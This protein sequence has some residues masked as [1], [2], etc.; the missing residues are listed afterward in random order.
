MNISFKHH[1]VLMTGYNARMNKQIYAASSNL[2][3]A[4]RKQ[5]VRA[6]FGTIIMTLN[7]VMVGD[8]LWLKRFESH[9]SDFPK[10]KS[11]QAFPEFTGLDQVITENFDLLSEKRT[12][13]D[14]IIIDWINDDVNEQDFQ[15]PI[16]YS[17][18]KG[19]AYK[20][21]FAELLFHFFNHQTHHRGQLSTMLS[22][23][24]HDIGITDFLIDIPTE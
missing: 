9:P 16:E 15:H 24:G 3:D 1:F 4:Q 2:T 22:Q 20:R 19:I 5:D 17:D 14:H 6:F 23:F 8:L 7:H 10:L 11:T 12:T 21:N 13:L 18:T